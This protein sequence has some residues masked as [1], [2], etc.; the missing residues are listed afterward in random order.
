M[1]WVKGPH[2]LRF[3]GE[4]TRVNLDKKFPQTFNGQIFFVNDNGLTDWQNFLEGQAAFSF[5]GGG[6]YDHEYRTNIFG[7]FAQDDWK[8]MK[9]LTLNLGLRVD[10]NGAFRDN[11]CH[12]GNIDEQLAAAGKY[13]MVYGGCANHLNI[14]GFTGSGSDTTFKNDYATGLAPR[15]GFAYDLG[16]RRT[17]S[18][19]GGYGIYYVREDV[20]AAD[21]LPSRRPTFPSCLARC[22]QGASLRFSRRMRRRNA[23]SRA[24]APTSTRCQ[25]RGSSIRASSPARQPS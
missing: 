21:Q 15:I 23:T 12:I 5:G 14:P 2:V 11:K 6:V 8:A 19:R 1:S 9:N 16:G 24:P 17:T 22:R 4:L 3:G 7:L 13:P 18:V 10:I 25:L 20:G